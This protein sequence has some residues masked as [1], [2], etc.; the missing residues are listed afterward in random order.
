[1]S[2]AE[3]LRKAAA[4][5]RETAAKATPGPWAH[6][7][8]SADGIRPRW[9][10]GPPTEPDDPWSA[11]DV[12]AVTGDMAQ[13]LA[14]ITEPGQLISDGDMDW[15]ALAS[16]A[17]AGPLAAWLEAAALDL[18]ESENLAYCDEPDSVRHAL[19]V[20]RAITREAGDGA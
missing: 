18:G 8:T 17:L 1:M 7:S 10:I 20:A 13:A 5:L 16:P 11:A 6:V 9:I 14:D 2:A 4:R 3:E 15:M 19:A 12:V